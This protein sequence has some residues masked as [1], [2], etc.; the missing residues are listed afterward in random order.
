[1]PCNHI[2][3]RACLDMWFDQ[4]AAEMGNLSCPMCRASV[5][6]PPEEYSKLLAEADAKAEAREKAAR[7]KAAAAAPA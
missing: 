1:M 6:C 3:C 5:G 4:N 2:A 7:E